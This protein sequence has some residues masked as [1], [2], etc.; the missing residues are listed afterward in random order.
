MVE[1]KNTVQPEE[2]KP[3]LASLRPEKRGE[4]AYVVFRLDAPRDIQRVTYGGRFYNR[5]P[6]AHTELL[7]S[8]DG[9]KTWI[10]SY[11]LVDTTSPWDVIHY[12]KVEGIPAGTK[13]VL[14]KYLWG[15]AGAGPAVC[16]PY[17]VRM[18]ANYAPAVAGARP[19]DVTFTW[20]ERQADYTTIQRSHTQRVLELPGTYEIRVGGA[21]HPIMESVRIRLQDEWPANIGCQYDLP[22]PKKFQDRWV[23]YGKNLA[24]GKPYTCTVP[25]REGWGANDG[26]GKIL[27][28]GIVGSPYVGGSAYQYGMLWHKGD[29]PQVTVDL[30]RPERCAAFR[31]QTGGYPFQDALKGEVQDQIEVL[32]STDD[33]QY[34]SQGRFDC[35]LR[36]KD[37]AVNDAW[38]DE[39]T[40]KGPNYLLVAKEPVQAR[41]VRFAIT[42]QRILSVSEV[43][44]LDSIAYEPFDLKLALP[45]G[46]DR[47][48]ITACNPRHFPSQARNVGKGGGKNRKHQELSNGQGQNNL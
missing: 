48:D 3:Y 15:A 30:G 12:E 16:G 31:I 5:G 8:F 19:V 25:S 40:L 27:T 29:Q 24:L 41:Y 26:G 38:P 37:I 17:A 46:R 45:D 13:S 4:D 6:N 34:A 7:H 22:G 42:P 20:N 36:W 39:E 43:Q 47:S 18:E 32:T 35:R 9:G 33:K 1:E 11:T 21:D 14:I 44:V 2:Q 23:T 10:S 28:D